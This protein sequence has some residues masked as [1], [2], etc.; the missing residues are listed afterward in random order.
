MRADF[1]LRD[2]QNGVMEKL[3][4]SGLAHLCIGVERVEDA[5]LGDWKKKFYSS[6]RTAETFGILKK[7]YPAGVPAGDVHRGRARRDARVDATAAEFAKVPRSGLPGVPSA[8]TLPGTAIYDEA[9]QKGW[10]EIEDFDY[11]DLNTPVMRSE[12]LTRE[13]I[14]EEIIRLNKGY[15]SLRW[16]LR[17]VSLVDEVSPQHVRL[18]APGDDAHLRRLDG[19]LPESADRDALYRPHRAGLVSDLSTRSA[20]AIFFTHSHSSALQPHSPA[21]CPISK[22]HSFS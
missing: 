12:T 17:G 3:V 1:I 6:N 2:H 5:Q 15:V 7:H 16:F 4:K 13:E 9:V 22:R 20:E 19:P 21:C 11:F 14:E 18:V 8:D 10:L